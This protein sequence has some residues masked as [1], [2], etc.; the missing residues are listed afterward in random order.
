MNTLDLSNK[1]SATLISIYTEISQVME[2][3]EVDFVVIGATARDIVLVHCF[4][5][6]IERG[7]RDVDFAISVENWDAFNLVKKSLSNCNF[8][9]DP[10]LCYRFIKTGEDGL[11][12]E[13]DVLPFGGLEKNN[14]IIWPPEHS[15][16]MSTYGFSEAIRSAYQ[17]RISEEVILPVASLEGMILLKLVAWTEREMRHREKDVQDFEYI[18]Q[19]CIN[20]PDKEQKMYN[21]GYMELYDFD[22]HLAAA[23]L[24]GDMCRDLAKTETL[25]YL[26]ESLFD[27]KRQSRYFVNEMVKHSKYG[28]ECQSIFD[29][30]KSSIIFNDEVNDVDKS[31]KK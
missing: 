6:K 29:I 16:I 28:K 21:D 18:I 10:N 3:H 15:V 24:M 9:E 20:I 30:F 23:S 2:K 27:N 22:Q 14:T 13:V 19:N 7:T 8:M 31:K 25:E 26:R 12:W 11:T 5:A 1:L 17:V 4:S